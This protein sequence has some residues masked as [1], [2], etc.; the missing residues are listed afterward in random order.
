MRKLTLLLAS[1][2]VLGASACA[3]LR[4]APGPGGRTAQRERDRAQEQRA[5]A[6]AVAD[7]R[8]DEEQR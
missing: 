3:S 1:L 7:I 5:T 8:S 6:R 2:F 4:P